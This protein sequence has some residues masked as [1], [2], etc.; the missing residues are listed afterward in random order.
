MAYFPALLYSITFTG[1]FLDYEYFENDFKPCN[2]TNG[3][4]GEINLN[5]SVGK[6]N[7]GHFIKS[8]MC[9]DMQKA[10]L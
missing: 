4:F 7:Q 9:F 1:G 10:I 6:W 2:T 3:D 5:A 8:S